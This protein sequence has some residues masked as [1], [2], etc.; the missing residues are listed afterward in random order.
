MLRLSED[1]VKSRLRLGKDCVKD[2]LRLRYVKK[3]LNV[4][5]EL[6][7]KEALNRICE[8]A[9]GCGRPVEPHGC[10]RRRLTAIAPGRSPLR[11]CDEKTAGGRVQASGRKK[12][13][14]KEKKKK[15]REKK[16]K[17]KKK[18]KNKVKYL[19]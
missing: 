4:K 13:K 5:S 17:R 18:R 16:K 10:E 19:D 11:S 2:R 8:R 1:Y 3:V 12:E 15:T 14:K 6:S 9:D 7:I